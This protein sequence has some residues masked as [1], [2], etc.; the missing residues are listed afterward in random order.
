MSKV[1][2]LYYSSYGHVETMA[3]AVA[4]G[5]RSVPGTEVVV[6]RVPELV[7]DEVAKRAHIKLDQAAPIAT[8]D[9]LADYDA[10]IFGTPTR[11]GMMAAQMRNFLDQTGGLWAKG[12]L[13]GKVGSAF[14]STASQHGG[15]ES[16]LLSFHTSLLH[17]GMVVVGL[18]YSFGGQT[19]LDEVTGG[20]PYGATTIAGGDGSRQPSA[21]ELA[22]ARFQGEHVARIAAKLTA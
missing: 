20:S 3:N 7:P 5:A 22:G 2:V 21:N 17:H 14:V 15:Q 13:I 4:E 12:A 10:I 11:F 1:L 6:K 8:P 9:E 19:T 16:T 18:P